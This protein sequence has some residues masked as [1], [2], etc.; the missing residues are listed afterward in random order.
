MTPTVNDEK[1][2]LS[3]SE[4]FLAAIPDL[5]FVLR[6]DGTFVDYR[7]PAGRAL[8]AEPE[9]VL[10]RTIREVLPPEVADVSE[11]ALAAALRG[12]GV[13]EYEYRLTMKDG[14][15][16]YEARMVKVGD[17]EVAAVVRDITGH[18][19][20]ERYR[21]LSAEILGI[22]NQPAAFQ[23]SLR[24]VLAAIQTG[25]G[26]DASGLR[27]SSGEDF[28]YFVQNGFASDF[29]LTENTLIARDPQ[30]GLCRGPDGSVSLECTC[31][32]V[33]SGRT[34]PSNPLFTPGGSAWTNDAFPLLDLPADAD[35]RLHP[36]NRCIHEGYASV[37]LIPI[38]M[39]RKIVGLLQINHRRKNQFSSG[40]V[41]ILEG[42]AAHIG[43]ALIRK[44]AEAALR[45]SEASFRALVET[46][47]DVVF[48]VAPDGRIASLSPQFTALT[49]WPVAEWVG[50]RFDGLIHAE[51]VP[52]VSELFARFQ[53]GESVPLF[54]LRVNTADGGVREF[55]VNATSRSENGQI[56]EV[57]GIARDISERM[58]AEN[59]R[60]RLQ[61]QFLQ[62]QKM[63]SVGRLAGGVAHDF[64]NLLMSIMGSAE[65]A[66]E[67]A[68]PGSPV[69]ERLGEILDSASR[70][71]EITRQ[72]LA[73]ARKQTI[74]PKVFDLNDHVST[75]LKLLR[76]MLDESINL[77]WQPGSQS[78]SVKMDPSQM[79]QLLAN[80]MVNLRDAISGVG[81]VTIETRWTVLSKAYCAEHE[82]AVPG[83]YVLL[84]VSDTGCGMDKATLAHIFEPFFT[85]KG[86]G[87]GTGLGLATVYGIVKQN[88]GYIEVKSERWEGTTFSIY[89]PAYRGVP[90]DQRSARAPAI[91]GG[92][93]TILVAEDE[94]SVR[95]A[96]QIILET[97]GYTVLS[98]E[99]PQQAL[100]MAAEYAGT[101]HLLL[102]DVVM[103]EFSGRELAERLG[104]Q[105]P[106]TR[107]LFISGYTADILGAHGVV[108]GGVQ[109]LQ[110]PFTRLDLARKVRDVLEKPRCAEQGVG[111]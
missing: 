34:D 100:R 82:G 3:S 50:K 8:Y 15:R 32:L 22:L 27:L 21:A 5:V 80:L 76:R 29:L 43:E 39:R 48:T 2:I 25:T 33:I 81:T 77:V 42:V 7:Q 102:T 92:T 91:P 59:E 54:E 46:V 93:E 44:Q 95:T 110:K 105:R 62:A 65:L 111:P 107:C 41:Q 45:E 97:C 28:P 37:A 106:E 78:M 55:E 109:Y 53:R 98:A 103:P 79:D 36:R 71:A 66:L 68:A 84:T 72:L 9:A 67:E 51:D 38:R 1:R 47:R 30:G 64:N 10:G 89:L 24:A 83:E 86:D 4:R 74:E 19:R 26:C 61:Q 58:K 99:T 31:G 104:K 70:S 13:Q 88:G 52:R 94:K 12:G 87:K 63:E 69:R 85:T 20:E 73:Y 57:I 49:G 17:E 90:Q 6:R 96:I 11:A 101:I 23:D 18:K 60:K 75:M 16:D 40:V 35:P 56:T 108:D 14:P